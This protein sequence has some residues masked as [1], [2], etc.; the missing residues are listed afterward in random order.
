[1]FSNYDA[2]GNPYYSG[3]GARAIHEIARRLAARHEVR[4]VTGDYPGARSEFI[5]GVAYER[6]GWA[7]AGPRL[8]QLLFQF[9]LPG[10]AARGDYDLWVESLTPPF[11]T[12]FLPWFTRRPVVALTQVLSGA[13]MA[14]KYRLPF[15]WVE[16]QGLGR[17]RFAVAL[18]SHLKRV[19]EAASPGIRVAVIPNGVSRELIDRE[20]D[21]SEDHVL[22]LGRI[23]I[24]QKGLDLLLEAVGRI[25]PRLGFP[26]VIAGAGPRSDE[27]FLERRLQELGLEGLVRWTGRVGEAERD[28]LMRR[29]LVMAMP[30]RFEASPLVLIEAFCHRVPVVLF[31]IPELGDIPGDCCVKVP[32]FDVAAYGEALLEVAGDP[33]RRRALGAA[34]KAYARRFDWD[35]LAQ[36]YERFFESI[37]SPGPRAGAAVGSPR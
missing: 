31:D 19:V 36:Q 35:E 26:V 1:V 22:F 12:A 5:D 24:E 23:D 16:R 7:N 27:A 34:G 20:G 8:G 3:G 9:R 13:A 11:S 21:R 32:A 37:L 30:S 10:R 2:L 17:Y 15:G 29:A 4:V 28:G 25:G 18:S 6:L 33:A 14:R